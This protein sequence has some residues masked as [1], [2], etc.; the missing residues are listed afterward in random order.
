MLDLGDKSEKSLKM[1]RRE[2]DEAG[3]YAVTHNV[4]VTGSGATTVEK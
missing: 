1:Q 3:R 4:I 2:R